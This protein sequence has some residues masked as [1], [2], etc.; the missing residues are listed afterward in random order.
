MALRSLRA[1]QEIVLSDVKRHGGAMGRHQLLVRGESMIA[2]VGVG[3]AA[4]LLCAVGAAAWWTVRTHQDA[5]REARREQVKML[6]EVLTHSAETMLSEKETS[7]LRWMMVEAARA[8]ELTEC[9]IAL[10]DGGVVAD[11]DPS[12]I[13]V[14]EL[15][16]R[17]S[18]GPIE[19]AA[20]SDD[21]Q[22]VTI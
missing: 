6:A 18:M 15:A 21:E 2:M 5:M 7:A 17:W 20:Q 9:R 12:K 13:T 1:R 16:E 3:G 19:A 10:P 22:K 14:K 8:N 4:I 11:A